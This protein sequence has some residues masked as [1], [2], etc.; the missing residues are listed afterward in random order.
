[1]SQTPYDPNYMYQS[2]IQPAP[3]R[4]TAVTVIAIIGIILGA[5][6]VLCMGAGLVMTITGKTF[7]ASGQAAE[8]PAPAKTA[9]IALG[10]GSVILWGLLLAGSVGALML[11]EWARKLLIGVSVVDLVFGI[12]KLAVNIILILPATLEMMQQNAPP[13][14]PANMVPIMRGTMYITAVLFWLVGAV[15]PIFTIV[16]MRK[17]HVVAAFRSDEPP[18]MA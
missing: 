16:I 6:G 12:A 3:Q 8:L 10:I 13:N 2:N 14:Q 7:G 17:P 15:L 1:L 18:A 4:P 5:L 11:Q 9:S